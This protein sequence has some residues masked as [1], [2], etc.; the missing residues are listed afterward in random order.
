MFT[1]LAWLRDQHD[2]HLLI[3]ALVVCVVSCAT[4]LAV[5]AR[6]VSA[7]KAARIGW[8]AFAGLVTGSGVWATHVLSMLAYGSKI[9]IAY[10]FD[11]TALSLLAAAAILSSGFFTAARSR[12]A[13]G[14]ML[15][16]AIV[17]GGV[18]A[19]HVVDVAAMSGPLILSWDHVL[20]ATAVLIAI[21][22]STAV[23]PSGRRPAAYRS[24]TSGSTP[25]AS[26]VR[27]A[28]D[29]LCAAS[30]VITLPR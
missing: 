7:M 23:R 19:M 13:W 24:E 11:L 26:A 1:V 14:R 21:I 12:K 18:A 5:Y 30:L 22:G 6:A 10:A 3:V 4:G 20:L 17:G 9:T 25:A 8:R 27:T 15:G 2:P 28:A 16:A 29:R